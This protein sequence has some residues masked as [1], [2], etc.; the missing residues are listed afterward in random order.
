MASEGTERDAAP[1]GFMAMEKASPGSAIDA[2]PI[3]RERGER[4]FFRK[5][6][7]EI[8]ERWPPRLGKI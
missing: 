1:A 7:A 4:S 2:P 5:V 8:P 6:S 3:P